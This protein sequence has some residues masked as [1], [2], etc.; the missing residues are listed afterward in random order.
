MQERNLLKR[1]YPDAEQGI[2]ILLKRYPDALK[3]HPDAIVFQLKNN[4]QN[5]G[6][7]YKF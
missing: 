2:R 6:K 7:A 1:E 3:G 5:A 4:E